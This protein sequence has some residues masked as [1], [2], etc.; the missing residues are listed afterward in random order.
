VQ[1]TKDTVCAF[2]TGDQLYELLPKEKDH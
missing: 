2:Y 1:R